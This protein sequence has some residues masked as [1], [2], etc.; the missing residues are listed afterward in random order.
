MSLANAWN[1][2]FHDYMDSNWNRESY[3]ILTSYDNATDFW[4]IFEIMRDTLQ[5]GMFFFM[6]NGVFPKW[7]DSYNNNKKFCFMSIKVLKANVPDFMEYMLV[8]IST[9]S[10][11][12]NA[13]LEQGMIDGVSVSP[14]KNFCI[15]K[16]W[17]CTQDAN[18]KNIDDYDIPQLYHGDAIFKD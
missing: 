17:I 6:K 10:L 9:D 3:E 7:D 13:E 1:V 2:Y 18:Y 14:K 16:L 5:M 8:R 4:T 11:L 15:I 12:T